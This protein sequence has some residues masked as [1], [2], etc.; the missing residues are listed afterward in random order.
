MLRI[1]FC[2]LLSTTALASPVL[3]QQA[4]EAPFFRLNGV[5]G[6][7]PTDPVYPPFSV[8]YDDFIGTV[9]TP[10]NLVPQISGGVSAGSLTWQALTPLMPGLTLDPSTGVISGTPLVAGPSIIRVAAVDGGENEQISP[11]FE[12]Y[13][14]GA[15][16]VSSNETEYSVRIGSDENA[17]FSF[18]A[19]TDA[20][21]DASAVINGETVYAFYSIVNS[22]TPGAPN[23]DIAG[24]CFMLPQP[25]LS[26]SADDYSFQFSRTN[27]YGAI[28]YGPVINV[29][30]LPQP[31]FI[32]PPEVGA[33]YAI[34]TQPGGRPLIKIL[35]NTEI[36]VLGT[37]TN[38][39]A[40]SD[41]GYEEY[42]PSFIP[43]QAPM[44]AGIDVSSFGGLWGMTSVAAGNRYN[45]VVIP[46]VSNDT[47][48]GWTLVDILIVNSL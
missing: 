41:P 13:F 8:N 42:W 18:C 25:A 2:F 27:A 23:G 36:V 30:Y 11:V 1:A 3:A 15:F 5:G 6:P 22:N 26:A 9:G 32:F 38:D 34:E 19:S 48:Y 7:A 24:N 12:V 14:N 33:G 17:V 40:Y 44:P 16:T 35:R 45:G 37:A 10:V 28:S 43:A 39:A 46:T 29:H 47:A 31:A 21:G 20:S 4:A